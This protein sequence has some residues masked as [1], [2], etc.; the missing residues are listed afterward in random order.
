MSA[1]MLHKCD[2]VSKNNSTNLLTLSE[3]EPL[4]RSIISISFTSGDAMHASRM[5]I[6]ATI[7]IP[8]PINRHTPATMSLLLDY[9]YLSQSIK[10]NN[11]HDRIAKNHLQ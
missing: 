5:P 9:P 6:T 4:R 7:N 10:L 11:S 8:A 1:A 2:Q 3:S